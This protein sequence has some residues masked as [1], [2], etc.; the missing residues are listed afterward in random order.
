M[1]VKQHLII[2]SKHRAAK[3][4][5]PIN[6]FTFPQCQPRLKSPDSH[7]YL[8]AIKYSRLSSSSFFV[9]LA[10]LLSVSQLP[11]FSSHSLFISHHASLASFRYILLELIL[12]FFG[13]CFA[14]F[15]GVTKYR[16]NKIAINLRKPSHQPFARCLIIHANGIFVFD[17]YSPRMKLCFVFFFIWDLLLIKQFDM[18]R[19]LE[20]VS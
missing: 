12:I 8:E 5:F 10:F 17:F 2:I 15:D 18:G 9:L 11:Y 3:L 19:A 4:S 1:L 6:K 20:M 7:R 16:L 13:S 14:R